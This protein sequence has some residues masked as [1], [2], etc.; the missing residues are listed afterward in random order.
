M[1][2]T[3]IVWKMAVGSVLAW[4]LAR[5]AG[6]AHPYLGPLTV[7]LAVK[8][9]PDKSIRFAWQRIGGTL[10]GVLFTALLLRSVT[11]NAWTLGLLLL[12]GG[13]ILKGLNM[14]D[15]V[16]LESAL[17]ILLVLALKNQSGYALDRVKD[18]IIGAIVAL[19]LTLVV[20]QPQPNQPKL[21]PPPQP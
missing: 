13:A 3:A 14:S 12:I 18:T 21:K 15:T 16:I 7:L 10:F 1:Q 5:W 8:S 2:R 20:P 17:S 19:L 11:P 4:E 9:S 6:S